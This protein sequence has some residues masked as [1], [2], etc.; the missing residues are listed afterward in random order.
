M[1]DGPL[2]SELQERNADAFVHVGDCFDDDLRYLTG[3]SGPDRDYAYVYDG[4][5][6][7]ATLCTPRLFEEQAREEFSGRVVSVAEQ[8]SRTAGERAAELVS[9]TVLVPQGIP[10][11]AA[12]WLERAGCGIESTDVVER[13]RVRKTEEE[14]ERISGVQDAAQAGMALAETVLASAEVGD[15]TLNWDG[16]SLTTERLRREVNAAM[17]REGAAPAGNTVIGAR[18][19]CADLHFTGDVPIGPGETVLIDLSPRGPAG[20]YGDLSRTFVVD[21]EGGWERRAYVAVER[22]Q[23]AAFE[24]LSAGAGTVA[25]AVHGETAAEISAYGFRPDGSPGFTHGAGHGVGMSLHEAPSLRADRELEAGM[26]LTVEPGVYDPEKG[27]VRIEDLVVVREEG[28]ENLT[29][30][31][32]SLVPQVRSSDQ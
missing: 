6:G 4:E 28:F 5:N 11:D 20:Y 29:D 24:V 19:S 31:P 12:L 15:G 13:M 3:F 21:S 10:H 17:A 1:N 25:S 22:A 9:G 23:D 26:V 14:I 16:E 2:D 8:S 18:E 30:Y 7:G 27:G 32:R